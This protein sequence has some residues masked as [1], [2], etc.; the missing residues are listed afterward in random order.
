MNNIFYLSK[1]VSTIVLLLG[2]FF[3]G[4]NFGNSITNLPDLVQSGYEDGLNDGYENNKTTIMSLLS[5]S[6]L[7]GSMIGSMA[8]SYFN[9]KFGYKRVAIVASILAAGINLL[10]MIKVHWVYLFIMRI[11]LGIP[12]S[13]LTTT[14]PS[15]LGE[16]ASV[17]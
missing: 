5:V 10:T 16:I 9:H 15:W 1:I 2:D 7:I 3:A 14:V 13:A 17:K 12:S 6:V 11:L 4:A 8:V